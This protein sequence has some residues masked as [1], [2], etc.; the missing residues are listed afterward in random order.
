MNRARRVEPSHREGSS[1]LHYTRT[2]LGTYALCGEYV[3]MLGIPENSEGCK[4]CVSIA[5]ERGYDLGESLFMDALEE[6][7]AET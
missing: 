7:N 6:T 4:E 5:Q 3:D 2:L 1:V